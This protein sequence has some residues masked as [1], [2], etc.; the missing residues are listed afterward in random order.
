VMADLAENERCK[1]QGKKPAVILRLA[2]EA[3]R[4]AQTRVLP[5]QFEVDDHR[6]LQ[7]WFAAG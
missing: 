1:A 6:W 4:S 3:A 5:H 2:L 7:Y